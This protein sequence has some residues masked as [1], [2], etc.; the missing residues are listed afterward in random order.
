MEFHSVIKRNEIMAHATIW[1]NLSERSQAQKAILYDSIYKKCHD[2]MNPK[3]EKVDQECQLQG[4]CDREQGVT[5]TKH[6]L[7]FGSNENV[8]ESVVMEAE[9]YEYTENY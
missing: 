1:M 8:L 6:R 3:K 2:Q 5:I 4:V 9:L 7:S